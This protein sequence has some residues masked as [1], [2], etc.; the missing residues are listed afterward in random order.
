[1]SRKHPK[2]HEATYPRH[3]H[4]KNALNNDDGKCTILV[5]DKK[6]HAP[7]LDRT[8]DLLLTIARIQ[9]KRTTTV[10]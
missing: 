5:E 6:R 7:T 4:V 9:D 10:L 3:Y 1:M 8:A 2:W